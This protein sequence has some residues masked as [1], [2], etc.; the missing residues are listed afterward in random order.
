VVG[1]LQQFLDPDAGEPQDLYGGPGPER[2]V[3]FGRQVPA[4]P[5]GRVIRPDPPGCWA[6][7]GAGQDL[8]GGS[9]GVP[10]PGLPR[11]SQQ[12]RG[13]FPVLVHGV[14]QDREDG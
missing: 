8:A 5:G 7:D 6:R 14:G 11:C 10:G 9:E 2:E 1:Y 3:L 4:L 12:F 13:G